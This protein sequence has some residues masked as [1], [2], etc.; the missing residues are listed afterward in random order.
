[1]KYTAKFPWYTWI[2][3]MFCKSHYAYDIERAYPGKNGKQNVMLFLEYKKM[4]GKMYVV[5]ETLIEY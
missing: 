3:L 4:R 1:M 2:G 5:K